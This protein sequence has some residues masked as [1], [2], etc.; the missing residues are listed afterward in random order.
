MI[1]QMKIKRYQFESI[2]FVSIVDDAD[3]PIDPYVSCYI[4]SSLGHLAPNTRLRY[5]N[6]L[7]FVLRHFA[8]KEIDLFTRV[9]SGELLSGEEYVQFY[10]SS[11]FG[12]DDTESESSIKFLDVENKI[13]RNILSANQKN[14]RR[15]SNETLSGRLRR[16]RKYI[17]WIFEKYHDQLS[18][19]EE[20]TGKYIKLISAIKLDES[21]VGRNCSQEVKGAEE[22]VIPE[23]IFLKLLEV[24]RPF[25]PNNPF[26]SS[27]VRN[28]IIVYVLF[29]SGIRRGALAKMKISDLNMF[30]S[31]DQ[32]SVYRSGND[33]TDPRLEKPNQKRGAHAALINQVL[34]K[35][36]ELYINH[37]RV[38][39]PAS[40]LHD[41]LF[42]S[43]K[44]SKGTAG[45]P[46]S[47]KA[48]NS[49]FRKISKVLGYHIHPHLLRHKWNEILDEAAVEQG[50]DYRLLE[51]IRK[52]CMG[53]SQNSEMT[54][55][56]DDRRLAIKARE[57]SWAHQK[58]VDFQ[59]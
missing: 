22:S 23:P 52:Y 56:Y 4:N 32:F 10:E 9:S 13:F 38:L 6:E 24:I 30:G 5:A 44:N 19:D 57:L 18:V 48:V 31:Y 49:I 41:Y 34:M 27:R 17:T 11:V 36:I 51:D 21:G 3:C 8:N 46:L 45:Q 25:S 2:P 47:L 37:V 53:W 1:C 15:V 55:V 42:V 43:E 50:V 16:L 39:F 7:L 28:Y 20:V 14:K 29:L 12:L 35:Q 40:Q 54:R 59:E 26:K 58:W 33:P